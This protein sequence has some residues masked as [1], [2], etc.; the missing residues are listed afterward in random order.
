MFSNGICSA[1]APQT[2]GGT[3]LKI[4]PIDNWVQKFVIPARISIILIPAAVIVCSK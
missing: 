3:M 4:I 2:T 1:I